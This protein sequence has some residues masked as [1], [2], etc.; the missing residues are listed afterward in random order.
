MHGIT[1]IDQY[2]SLLGSEMIERIKKKA[3]RLRGRHVV[4]VNSTYSGGGV[5]ELLSSLTLL[6][7]DVG[8]KTGWRVLHGSA[9]FFSVTKKFHN[10]LQGAPIHLTSCKKK[11][12]EDVIFENSVRN[13]LDHDIVII[14]DPQALAMIAHYKKRDHGYGA[15]M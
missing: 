10:A 7:N 8:I 9:D 11:I 3:E 15:A 13:H 4:H 6:M 12:Y 2:K 5:A 1:S 14:H